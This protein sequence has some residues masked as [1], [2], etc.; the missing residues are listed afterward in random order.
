MKALLTWY[1]ILIDTILWRLRNPNFKVTS[2][3]IQSSRQV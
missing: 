2:N 1:G 3:Y